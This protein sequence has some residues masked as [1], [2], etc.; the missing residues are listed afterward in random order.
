MVERCHSQLILSSLMNAISTFLIPLFSLCPP[1]LSTTSYATSYMLNSQ[2]DIPIAASIE[3]VRL[4]RSGADCMKAFKLCKVDP[5][6]QTIV[7]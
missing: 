1:P 2:R 3:A 6:E 5:L 7:E 4:G